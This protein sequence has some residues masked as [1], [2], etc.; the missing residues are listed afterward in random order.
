MRYA[1]FL[2]IGLLAGVALVN[3]YEGEMIKAAEVSRA[4]LCYE[5]GEYAREVFTCQRFNT[6]E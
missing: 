5:M 6:Y 1:L 2:A 4:E 3:W